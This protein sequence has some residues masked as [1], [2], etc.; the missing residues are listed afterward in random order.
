MSIQPFPLLP[1]HYHADNGNLLSGGKLYFYE[2]GTPDTIQPVYTDHTGLVEYTQPVVLNVRG[3]PPTEGVYGSDTKAYKIVIKT[4]AGVTIKTINGFRFVVDSSGGGGGLLFVSTD[5]TL[6]GDGTTVDPLS[7][8]NSPKLGGHLPSHFAVDADVVHLTGDETIAGEKTFSESLTVQNLPVATDGYTEIQI[9][10]DFT[11]VLSTANAGTGNQGQSNL[12][13]SST[14]SALT[15][16]TTNSSPA[17]SSEIKLETSAL[18][19]K[20]IVLKNGTYSELLFPENEDGTFA[21]REYVDG[22]YV[23]KSGDTMTGDLI[24]QTGD[25]SIQTNIS[26]DRISVNDYVKGIYVAEDITG[27]EPYVVVG[28]TVD[29]SYLYPDKL[30]S[31]FDNLLFPDL[32]GSAGSEKTETLATREWVANENPPQLQSSG[33]FTWTGTKFAIVDATHVRIGAGTGQ[34]VDTI[35]NI[36]K[37]TWAENTNLLDAFVGTTTNTYYMVDSTGAFV[38]YGTYPTPTMMRAMIYLGYTAHAPVGTLLAITSEPAYAVNEMSQVRDIF[39]GALRHV[40]EDVSVSANGANLSLNRSA[41]Y[42]YGLG[43]GFSTSAT[44]PSRIAISSGT[45]ITFQYRTQTGV[46]TGNT[47][48]VDTA[49]YDLN[50]T[51]TAIPS[52]NKWTNQWVFVFPSGQT[53][54]QLGQRY[55]NSQAEAI[56]SSQSEAFVIYTPFADNAV[57]VQVICVKQ[58]ST[59]LNSTASATFIPV[60]KFGERTGGAGGSATT[61]LQQAYDNSA[62]PE[63]LTD[64]TRGALSVKRGSGADTDIVFEVLNG[65]G[66]VTSSINGNGTIKSA[67]LTSNKITKANASKELVD[68]TITDDGTTITASVPMVQAVAG[69]DSIQ[70]VRGGNAKIANVQFQTNDTTTVVGS[71]GRPTGATNSLSLIA[72]L[73]YLNLNTATAG[74]GISLQ[75]NSVERAFISDTA[76]TASVPIQSNFAMLKKDYFAGDTVIPSGY[77]MEMYD[78]YTIESADSLEVNGT[79]FVQ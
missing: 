42:L 27:A 58:N 8:E 73:E 20:A 13:T 60:S 54:I 37:V 63:I 52:S 65:G 48:S 21:T 15:L 10:P 55:Y 50:G 44:D 57:L 22:A 32:G 6:S 79:L 7:V 78:A 33:L 77:T 11:N 46:A 36:V 41:G 30:K 4:S 28:G 66:T 17:F 75:T 3:E 23:A 74:K 29:K 35:G 34:I 1:I 38:Q 68:S 26:D 49:N 12:S 9:G 24:V 70:V 14:Q 43:L 69:A 16:N 72:N 31:N 5:S 53:R 62:T 40:N 64:A 61:T 45:A 25:S 2:A 18:G 76:I 39:D 56:A 67:P 59:V 71:V 19:A 51:I 47:T